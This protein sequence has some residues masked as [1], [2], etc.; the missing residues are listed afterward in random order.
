[1]EVLPRPPAQNRKHQG[2]PEGEACL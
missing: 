1:V 2:E